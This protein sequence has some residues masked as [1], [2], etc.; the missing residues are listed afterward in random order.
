MARMNRSPC[1]NSIE[2]RLIPGCD[3]KVGA[4]IQRRSA[5]IIGNFK[6]DGIADRLNRDPGIRVAAAGLKLGRQAV[7]AVSYESQRGARI[8]ALDDPNGDISTIQGKVA[9]KQRA[10]SRG[11]WYE[12]WPRRRPL[13]PQSGPR[14]HRCSRSA[15]RNRTGPAIS[16]GEP[17]P[18]PTAAPR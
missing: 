9:I 4:V 8:P 1:V 17:L 5:Q 6:A 16:A 7:G 11:R 10:K 14:S 13:R 12:R 15:S 3:G 18:A 2:S